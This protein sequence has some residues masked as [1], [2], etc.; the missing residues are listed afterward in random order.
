MIA[1]RYQKKKKRRLNRFSSI[2]DLDAVKFNKAISSSNSKM[3]PCK[4]AACKPLILAVNTSYRHNRFNSVPDLDVVT[5]NKA[6][7]SS[8]SKMVRCKA[9]SSKP[10]LLAVIAGRNKIEKKRRLN[11]RSPK[12]VWKTE[13]PVGHQ[14]RHWR[15][16]KNTSIISV[17]TPIIIVGTSG[18]V[19][20]K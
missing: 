3:V 18:L 5:I 11:F 12:T 4:Y 13:F 8:N 19:K 15:I 16:P 10:E 20:V 1:R 6:I 17:N 9:S 7:N 14:K 2:L